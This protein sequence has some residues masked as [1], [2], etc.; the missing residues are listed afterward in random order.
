MN[1]QTQYLIE[2]AE[3]LRK[4]DAS[5]G[6]R[7]G[8][9]R[10]FEWAGGTI[11]QNNVVEKYNEADNVLLFY[12]GLDS[13]ARLKMAWTFGYRETVLTPEEVKVGM[14]A[15]H[16]AQQ[17]VSH[18][19]MLRLLDAGGSK[20]EA[21]KRSGSDLLAIP[22]DRDFAAMAWYAEQF[23]TSELGEVY[24]NEIETAYQI[25][26]G[27]GSRADVTLA[28]VKGALNARAYQVHAERISTFQEKFVYA[29]VRSASAKKTVGLL[30][31]VRDRLIEE[32]KDEGE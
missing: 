15:L 10:K 11:P 13:E 29:G 12:G 27:D 3:M 1:T 25:V 14:D 7:N 26:V 4:W 20:W 28:A 18:A 2:A 21:F 5:G 9:K 22:D 8:R 17:S 6:K 24:R 31:I 30:R 19:D 23:L 32:A 16:D